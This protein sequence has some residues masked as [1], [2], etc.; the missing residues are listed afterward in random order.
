[1]S[2]IISNI[3]QQQQQEKISFFIQVDGK[4]RKMGGSK[5]NM[6]E[7]S[8]DRF[9]CVQPIQGLGLKQIKIKKQNWRT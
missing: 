3:G 6:K 4:S 7:I 9:K 8:K 2:F 5:E 1:M